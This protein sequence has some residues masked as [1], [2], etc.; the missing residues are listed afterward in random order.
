MA[1]MDFTMFPLKVLRD[2]KW[3]KLRG[4]LNAQLV[5]RMLWACEHT[6]YPGLFRYPLPY[7]SH[8]LGNSSEET[9]QIFG[10]LANV[11]LIEFNEITGFVRLVGWY[12]LK[13]FPDSLNVLKSRSAPYLD[14][15]LPTDILT[16]GSASDLIVASYKHARV[17]PRVTE[18]Q[19]RHHADYVGHLEM[20]V[21]HCADNLH[22]FESSLLAEFA[23]NGQELQTEYE[24]LVHTRTGLSREAAE[25]FGLVIGEDPLEALARGYGNPP[26]G[27]GNEKKREDEEKKKAY[28]G[29]T[30]SVLSD[31]GNS[32][33]RASTLKSELALSAN[34]VAP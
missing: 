3:L 24:W 17:L 27:L 26:Q 8:D 11:G 6:D 5:Y 33:P 31:I 7:L 10:Q 13:Y 12:R 25:S 23:E 19:K 28:S 34:G 22:G 9:R 32:G 14:G 1:K 20:L 15:S 30:S 16:S 29:T 2:P 21:R 18:A 4:D